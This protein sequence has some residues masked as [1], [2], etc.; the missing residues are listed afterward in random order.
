[1]LLPKFCPGIATALRVLSFLPRSFFLPPRSLKRGKTR[2]RRAGNQG[3]EKEQ[4]PTSSS[5]LSLYWV[6][7]VSLCEGAFPTSIPHCNVITNLLISGPFR[8]RAW[9]PETTQEAT[10][11]GNLATLFRLLV[12]PDIQKVTTHLA[13]THSLLNLECIFSFCF[14]FLSAKDQTPENARSNAGSPQHEATRV[15]QVYEHR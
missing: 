7:E 8:S 15:G 6:A 13:N 11:W 14:F 10:I 1:M 5:A 9:V 2:K 12:I 3:K 4:L